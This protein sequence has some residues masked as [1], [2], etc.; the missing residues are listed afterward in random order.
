[1]A[2]KHDTPAVEAAAE[3]VRELLDKRAS[4]ERKTEALKAK[5]GPNAL[6]DGI[7]IG[8]IMK[9]RAEVA[10]LTEELALV[11][12][13]ITIA[14]D[15]LERAKAEAARGAAQAMRSDVDALLEKAAAA[16]LE[17]RSL[18][19]ADEQLR[20][21]FRE[22]GHPSTAWPWGKLTNYALVAMAVQPGGPGQ[23]ILD[24][25]RKQTSMAEAAA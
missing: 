18:V 12:Q 20:R 10:K 15:R 17:L 16:V 6:V 25:H 14:E 4:I 13:G 9:A 19:E 7:D 23:A 5:T 1:M 3:I 21:E 11:N 22:A 8:T 24:A 2:P